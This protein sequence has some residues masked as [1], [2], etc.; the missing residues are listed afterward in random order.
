MSRWL[1]AVDDSVWAS[2]AF[3]YTLTYANKETDRIF[4]MHITEDVS[5]S[6]VGYATAGLIT[7]LK[8]AQEEK[9]RK[10]LVHYG[11]KCQEQGIQFTM[12]KGSDSQPGNL[13]C[14][15]VVNYDISTVIIGRRAMGG[16]ERF[17]VG[18][19]SKYVVENAE[20]NVIVIKKPFGA[21]EEHEKKSSI[22]QAEEAERVR[23]E[24]EDGPAEVHDTSVADIK[25][26]EE[27]ERQR[28]I[29]EDGDHSSVSIDKLFSVY[30][31]QSQLSSSSSY[32]VRLPGDSGRIGRSDFEVSGL[33]SSSNTASSKST[34]TTFVVSTG[35]QSPVNR[36]VMT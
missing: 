34:T 7:S 13:L 29:K 10:I 24:E 27:A 2:Y 22:I 4:L 32:Y 15:A 16:V 28:R 8:D 17:F 6:Y 33:G 1:V 30:K 9:A 25:A 36:R 31:F 21:P 11:H 18:S 20:C 26:Q 14:K 23:R 35:V 12:M 19:T 5:Q 3:N